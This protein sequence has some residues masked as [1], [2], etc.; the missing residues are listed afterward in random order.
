[1]ISQQACG[2]P[3]TRGPLSHS[4]ELIFGLTMIGKFHSALY[5]ALV[6]SVSVVTFLSDFSLLLSHKSSHFYDLLCTHQDGQSGR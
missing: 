2:E 6:R 4:G 1:M 5:L 3:L